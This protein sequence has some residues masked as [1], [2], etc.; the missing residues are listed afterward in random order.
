MTMHAEDPKWSFVRRDEAGRVVEVVEKRVVSH[1]A[2]VGIY[3][4]A[5]GR[6]FVS[7]AEAMIQQGLRVNGEFYV[8]PAYN[9]MVARGQRIVTRDIGAVGAGM[10]GIGVP[11][12]LDA[13]VRHPVAARAVRGL[14]P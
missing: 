5:R 13:F 2:T 1:E 12:D 6:D 11:A 8:A 9:Q 14:R 10:Y 4:F 3:N 7:A